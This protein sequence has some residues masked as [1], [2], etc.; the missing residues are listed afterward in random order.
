MSID[1]EVIELNSE[2]HLAADMTKD[3]LKKAV[4]DYEIKAAFKEYDLYIPQEELSFS[5]TGRIYELIEHIKVHKY[6]MN[7][8][9]KEE[10]S[11]REAAKS[12]YKDLYTPI[13]ERIRED[14]L[15]SRFPGRTESDLYMWIMN[16]WHVLKEKFGQDFPLPAAAEDFTIRF[17][18]SI[19][20]RVRVFFRR[21]FRRRG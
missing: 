17:G 16:H 14:N 8:G 10:I 20:D 6:F 7:Q 3:D 19:V 4:I 12:W 18:Q 2:I 15:L 1:A 13:V 11:F 21:L 9:I 5:A